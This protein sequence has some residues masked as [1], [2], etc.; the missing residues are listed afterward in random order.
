MLHNSVPMKK[1]RRVNFAVPIQK[2][3]ASYTGLKILLRGGSERRVRGGQQGPALLRLIP[4]APFLRFQPRRLHTD[5]CLSV[6]LV[7]IGQGVP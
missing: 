5:L 3:T 7:M 4:A 1:V 2:S 6:E